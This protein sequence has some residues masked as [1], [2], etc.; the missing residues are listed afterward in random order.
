MTA[1]GQ[2]RFSAGG[3]KQQFS[4]PFLSLLVVCGERAHRLKRDRHNLL[5]CGHSSE[6]LRV[7]PPRPLPCGQLSSI[8]VTRSNEI[9]PPRFSHLGSCALLCEAPAPLNLSWQRRIWALAAR[10][11]VWPGV[12]EVMP[13]MNNL[14]LVFD[15]LVLT[16]EEIKAEIL[17]L[18]PNCEWVGEAGKTLEI[19]VVY[20]GDNGMDL[21]YV[22]RHAGLSVDEVV[23]LHTNATYT[24]YFLGAYPGFAYLDGLHPKLFTPRRQEPRMQVPAGS[25]A[26]GGAQA[27]VIPS[28][29]PSGWQI[30]GHAREVFFDV[31][32]NPPAL[33]APG[34]KINFRAE[35]IER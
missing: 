25:V 4:K 20:G 27:G 3:R 11:E 13:G 29:V 12:M 35:R 9:S 28:M 30:I 6:A 34:D 17:K 5:Y 31:A 22:A 26:I 33:L 32:N 10:V 2:K 15:P 16:A 7:E 8:D 14:M 23:K 19:A 24:V 18:W 1:L 21:E